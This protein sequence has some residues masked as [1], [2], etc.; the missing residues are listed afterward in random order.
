MDGDTIDVLSDWTSDRDYEIRVAN[1]S[2]GTGSDNRQNGNTFLRSG[3]DATIFEDDDEDVL[4]GSAGS[5]WFFMD[6]QQDR[7]T[8]LK[9][10]IFANDLDFILS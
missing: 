7:A 10:E 5:D 8:D 2:N 3:G 4:T 1:L 9:D 6:T